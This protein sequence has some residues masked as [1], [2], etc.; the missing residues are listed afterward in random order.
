MQFDNQ[1]M[2]PHGVFSFFLGLSTVANI[3]MV[4]ADFPFVKQKGMIYN[5]YEY[6]LHTAA[7]YR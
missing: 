1:R 4:H 6:F 2:M 7:L 3:C 5:F